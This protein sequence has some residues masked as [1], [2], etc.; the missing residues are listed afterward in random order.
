MYMFCRAFMFIN[1]IWGITQGWFT[2][3][4]VMVCL[5]HASNISL[6]GKANII[7]NNR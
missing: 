2:S 7:C 1:G 4:G 5:I 3:I 6:K